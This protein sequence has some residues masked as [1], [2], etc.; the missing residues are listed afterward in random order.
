L[1]RIA[2]QQNQPDAAVK[3]FEKT[4]GASPD[5]F[6]KAWSLVY[7]ARLSKASGDPARAASLYKEALAVPGASERALEAARKESQN[8][9]TNQ[10]TPK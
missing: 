9:S 5:A 4:L 10:E 7:L 1:A 2:L 8:I 6:T 3:L